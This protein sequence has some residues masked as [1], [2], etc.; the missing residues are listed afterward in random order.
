MLAVLS[1]TGSAAAL[2]LR[3]AVEHPCFNHASDPALIA[4]IA[5]GDQLAMR[6]LFARHQTAVYRWIR[7]FVRDEAS[8]EDLV[9]EVFFDVWRQAGSFQARSSV[10]TWL[11]AI[12]R[13]KALSAC[14]R[15]VDDQ[16]D[17]EFAANIHDP[18]AD[19]ETMLIHKNR[20]ELL[21]Q[22]VANLSRKHREVLDLVYY[23]GKSVKEVAEIAGIPEATVK[24]R[25]LHARRKL[26]DS[27][28]AA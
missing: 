4:R 3:S 9:S 27:V 16:L 25:M 13:H 17:E 10:S 19:P 1:G 2:R 8:A 15:R 11:L 5:K 6:T 7:R 18:G 14:R 26:A 28:G 24:T 22:S 23:H 12:A 21:R 20:A